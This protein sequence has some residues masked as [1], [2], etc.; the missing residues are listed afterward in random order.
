MQV[1]SAIVNCPDHKPTDK[2]E[3]QRVRNSG[4]EM[5]ENATRIGGLA[6]SRALGDHFLKRE[7]LGIISK[8]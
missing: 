8:V 6:V 3:K 7:N 1:L 2:E 5:K 4:I